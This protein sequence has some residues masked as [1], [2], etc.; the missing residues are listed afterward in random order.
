ML[1]VLRALL[2]V[3]ME[4]IDSPTVQMNLQM[5]SMDGFFFV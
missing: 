1:V 3:F 2:M 5:H 4:E